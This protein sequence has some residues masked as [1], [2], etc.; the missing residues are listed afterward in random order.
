MLSSFRNENKFYSC[1]KGTVTH[2]SSALVSIDVL[3]FRTSSNENNLPSPT[4]SN[5]GPLNKHELSLL[6]PIV[7]AQNFLC[8]TRTNAKGEYVFDDVL[9]GLYVV[10]CIE[11]FEL[12]ELIFFFF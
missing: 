9:I 5:D 10:V 7:N 3:L 8:R 12:F 6:P 4:C 1:I 11:I 2:Q